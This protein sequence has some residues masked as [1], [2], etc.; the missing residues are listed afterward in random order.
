MVVWVEQTFVQIAHD[1]LIVGASCPLHGWVLRKEFERLGY[2]RVLGKI[3][4]C[5]LISYL[6]LSFRHFRNGGVIE[7][8]SLGCQSLLSLLGFK[9]AFELFEGK[10][11]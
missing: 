4:I 6:P 9:P 3:C 5:S 2:E 10:K 8:A 1:P 7:P 11:Y